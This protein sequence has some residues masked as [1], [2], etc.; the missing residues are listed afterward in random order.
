MGDPDISMILREVEFMKQRY[1]SLALMI[2]LI[3][4]ICAIHAGAQDSDAYLLKIL[5]AVQKNVNSQK[6]RMVDYVSKEEIT[7]EEFNDEGKIKK[8]TNII[9]DYRIFPE[10]ASVIS[11]CRIVSEILGSVQ[12]SGILREEREM[13]SVKE[14]NNIIKEFTEAVWAKGNSYVDYFILF[15]KQNEKCFDYKLIGR[16]EEPNAYVIE[17]KQKEIDIGKN[18]KLK[19]ELNYEGFAFIDTNTMEIVQ[20]N[21]KGVGYHVNYDGVYMVIKGITYLVDGRD[22]VEDG[23]F[24]KRLIPAKTV[25]NYFFSLNMGTTM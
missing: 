17:I 9:S 24:P 21:R 12:P 3:S 8:T 4:G 14:D 20:L 7:V 22:D 23:W 15:D 10:T 5:E 6:E 11:D 1:C 2:V 25:D 18:E 13:L 16:M 19:W